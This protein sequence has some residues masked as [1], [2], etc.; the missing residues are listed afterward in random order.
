M[1][2]SHTQREKLWEIMSAKQRCRLLSCLRPKER[3]LLLLSSTSLLELSTLLLAMSAEQIEESFHVKRSAQAAAAILSGASPAQ[4]LAELH[5]YARV[6]GLAAVPQEQ[7]ALALATLQRHEAMLLAAGL[8]VLML[9][10]ARSS[11]SATFP[12][13]SGRPSLDVAGSA[14]APERGSN[15][16]LEMLHREGL[17]ELLR[18][19]APDIG[20]REQAENHVRSWFQEFVGTDAQYQMGWGEAACR[21]P[22]VK[23]RSR[24]TKRRS[25][26]NDPSQMARAWVDNQKTLTVPPLKGH[27]DRTSMA[28]DFHNTAIAPRH[29]V[30]P[31][32]A[33]A[34]WAKGSFDAA[35]EVNSGRREMQ[36]PLRRKENPQ[37]G[38]KFSSIRMQNSVFGRS[39][40]DYVRSLPSEQRSVLPKL[41]ELDGRQKTSMQ[42]CPP[43]LITKG[44]RMPRG[45]G[46]G[47]PP[48]FEH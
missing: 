13:L 19:I 15:P 11:T 10:S 30:L 28:A 39:F 24:P 14:L 48:I 20:G 4:V 33:S 2:M 12:K 17:T 7:R 46:F 9:Q 31:K 1:L 6:A 16:I 37:R 3:Q 44:P 27:K 40:N 26:S 22:L 45:A 42:E 41:A 18:A 5:L 43:H 23:Q 35:F 21:T 34:K 8:R 29:L 32:V 47:M 38:F 36:K 25:K